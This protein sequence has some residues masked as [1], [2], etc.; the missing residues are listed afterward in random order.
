MFS[1]KT[2][3]KSIQDWTHLPDARLL[4]AVAEGNRGA[5]EALYRR[6]HPRLLGFAHRWIEQRDQAEEV[7]Q[8]VMF[9][10]WKDAA[11]FQG[12]SRVSTWIF[13]ITY[14]Q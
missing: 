13:G 7:V 10:V 2:A 8:E 4:Q 9:A 5:F 3:S 14:R 1:T 11:S 12:R 6:Y